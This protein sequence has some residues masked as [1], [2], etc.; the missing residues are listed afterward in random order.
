ME[1]NALL[2]ESLAEFVAAHPQ[3]KVDWPPVDGHWH[4]T[5]SLDCG[6]GYVHADTEAG[7][8]AKL[9]AALDG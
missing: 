2:P 5:V 3:V 4:A 1:G 8:L 6:Y 9:T 7:L